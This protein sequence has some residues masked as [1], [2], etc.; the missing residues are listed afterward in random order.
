MEF[1]LVLVLLFFG[2]LLGGLC[3]WLLSR[4][5]IS[6][7]FLAKTT[8]EKEYVLRQLYQTA[9]DDL[10]KIKNQLELKEEKLRASLQD[11]AAAEQQLIH[12]GERLEKQQQETEKLQEKFSTEFENLANRLLEE[13]SEKFS[14]QNR[15]QIGELLNPLK[16]KI[17]GFEKE[18]TEVYQS[19]AKDRSALQ[20]EIKVLMELNQKISSEANELTKALKGDTKKQGN[21]GEMIL[22][23]V[24]ERSG[25]V[26]GQEFELQYADTTDDGRRI[27]PDVIVH[28]PDKKHVIMDAKVSLI[29]Y[30]RLVNAPG[31]AEQKQA[32]KA[33]LD[34]VR[35]HIKGLAEKNYPAARKL[36]CPDFVLMFLPVE[37]SFSAA[38][39]GDNDLFAYA[40]DQRIVLV[41]PSTLLASLRTIA[42]TWKQ[43]KQTRHALEIARQA[44]SL[45]DKFVGFVEDMK[46]IETGIEQLEKSY[47]SAM[48]KLQYGSGNLIR[49][50]ENIRGLGI[51]TAKRLPAEAGDEQE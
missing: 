6:D 1:T 29:A 28:L 21:W 7:D 12:F 37:S 11:L 32:L 5:R 48:N 3:G 42:A 24:L 43:E 16:E 31:E 14:Q 50:A 15:K 46:K 22:E 10:E 13:K 49:R 33:H 47:Q 27:Q 25:L 35:Q 41:S 26:K 51:K 44:G 18:V 20:G 30:E 8:V 38:V 40:W 36:N 4:V 23:R 17:E 45:Y 2:I 19:E 39:Q 34:S 9:A